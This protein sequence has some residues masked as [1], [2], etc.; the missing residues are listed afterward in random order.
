MEKVLS[1]N[2]NQTKLT[3][4]QKEAVG[5]LSIGTFLEYFDLMLYVHMAVLLNELFFPKTDPFTESL[6]SA[7][8]FCS[9]YLLRPFAAIIFGYIGDKIGRKRTVIITTFMMAVSCITM[10]NLPSYQQIG[11]VASYAMVLC[12]IVQG[13]S[14]LGEITGAELYVTEMTKPP[15]QYVAVSMVSVCTLTGGLVALAFAWFCNSSGLSWRFAF[16]IGAIIAVIGMTARAKLREAPDYADAR[17]RIQNVLKKADSSIEMSRLNE[18]FN[19]K[20]G[21][22][23]T[24]SYLCILSIWPA[25]FFL[26]YVYMGNIFKFKFGYTPAEVIK[27]NFYVASYNWCVVVSLIILTLKVHPLKI[28]KVRGFIFL[29]AMPFCLYLLSKVSSPDELF[30]LQLLFITTSVCLDPAAAVFYKHFPIF[31][32]FRYSSFMHAISKI[33]VY[34]V[35]SFGLVYLTEISYY[36][37][38][39]IMV[40]LGVLFLLSVSHFEEL[41]RVNKNLLIQ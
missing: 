23:T 40:P 36:G 28:L 22:K 27:N 15:I 38:L 37:V 21:I 8:S 30:K 13:L 33:L 3:R 16:W 18:L 39:V 6:L 14:S 26:I 7:L 10:A 32:R 1:A 12:R 31:K 24:F 2:N 35:T 17:L 9:L 11:I 20:I 41:E 29:L 34:V 4:E 19:A 25:F 5:L